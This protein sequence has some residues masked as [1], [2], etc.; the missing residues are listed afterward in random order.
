MIDEAKQKEEEEKN[1]NSRTGDPLKDF[2][3]DLKKIGSSEA[4]KYIRLGRQTTYS[5]IELLYSTDWKLD[6]KDSGV[7][8]YSIT[9]PGEGNY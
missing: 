5:F 1:A 9:I 3:L 7:K 2:E 6:K 4:I 8:I